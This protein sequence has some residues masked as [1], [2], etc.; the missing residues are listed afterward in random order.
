MVLNGMHLDLC[1]QDAIAAAERNGPL[2]LLEGAVRV[3]GARS[4]M[5]IRSIH[6]W[7]ASLLTPPERDMLSRL[8]LFRYVWLHVLH[9]AG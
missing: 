9:D 3:P 2:S 4:D 1:M 7:L 6:A 8:A 5:Q